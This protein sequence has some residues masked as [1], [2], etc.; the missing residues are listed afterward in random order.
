M[1]VDILCCF[2]GVFFWSACIYVF[3]VKKTSC[4]LS[5]RLKSYDGVF[6]WC[7]VVFVC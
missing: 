6:Y 2:A 3:V 4:F 7:S 5:P 1:Y